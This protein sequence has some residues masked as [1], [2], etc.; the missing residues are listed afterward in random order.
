[1]LHE[2]TKDDHGFIR[3]VIGKIQLL[4]KSFVRYST[5]TW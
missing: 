2:L 3:F 1:M 4:K 5:K